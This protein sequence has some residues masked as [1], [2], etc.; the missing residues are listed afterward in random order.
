MAGLKQRVQLDLE[1][2]TEIQTAYDGRDLRAWEGR[3]GKPAI[4]TDM[5]LSMLAFLGYSA[6]KRDGQLNGSYTRYEDFDKVCT[7]VQILND[8]DTDK[9]TDDA[10]ER[11]TKGRK[12]AATRKTAGD[13]PSAP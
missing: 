4:G 7:W 2:G 9:D 13:A 11:P 3:S 12:T 10:T 8:E 6:A 1:D 5:T